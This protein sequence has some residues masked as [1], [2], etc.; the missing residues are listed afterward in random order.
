LLAEPQVSLLRLALACRCPHCGKGRQ[1]A[2]LLEVCER[3]EVSGLDLRGHDAGDGAIV[4][5]I[6]VLGAIVVVLAFWVEFRFSPPLW[7]HAILWPVVTIPAAVLMMRPVKA[8]L[9][10]LQYRNRASEMGL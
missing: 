3:C 5:V 7:V 9:V 1:F 6:L 8:A 4:G 2:G 10:A